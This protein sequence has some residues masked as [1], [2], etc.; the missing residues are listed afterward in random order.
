[1]DRETGIMYIGINDIPN[2]VQLVEHK[3]ESPE[4]LAAMPLIKAGEILYKKN[5]AA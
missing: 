3:E 4:E 5:C 2:I 1:V